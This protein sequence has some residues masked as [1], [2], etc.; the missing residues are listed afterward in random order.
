MAPQK[1]QHDA[2]AVPKQPCLGYCKQGHTCPIPEHCSAAALRDEDPF[3][4]L[5]Q[6]IVWWGKTGVLLAA[7]TLIFLFIAGMTTGILSIK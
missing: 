5:V 3:E 4:D 6:N 7:G 2:T 1:T